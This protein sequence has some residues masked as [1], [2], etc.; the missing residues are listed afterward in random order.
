[1]V[2]TSD[3]WIITRTGIRERRILKDPTKATSDMAAN[4]IELLLKKTES[5]SIKHESRLKY[6]RFI[7]NFINNLESSHS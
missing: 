5:V 3:E 4:A 2:D 7:L 1:M 6:N